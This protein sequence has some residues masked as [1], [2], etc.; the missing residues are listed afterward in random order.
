MRSPR[1]S[2]AGLMASIALL[3]ATFS[4]LHA[5][6]E[7]WASV[8]LTLA[9]AASGCAL[10]GRLSACGIDQA[11]WNGFLIFG[12][13]YLAI[14]VGPW[15][16]EHIM[17]NLVTTP[18]IDEQYSKM[19]YAPALTGERVWTSDGTGREYAGG[20]VFG[21]V[22]AE[23]TSFDVAHDR[24]TTS[25]YYSAQL[26]PIS[27]DSYRRLCHSAVSLW[28]GLLGALLARYFVGGRRDGSTRGRGEAS[29]PAA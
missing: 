17:P 4:A 3:G 7:F 11:T 29:G 28:V 16:D 15:C 25:R 9:I 24:G 27:P 26:R 19:Q 22:D 20:R 10:L 6:T 1:I 12:T 23:T 18:F 5:R 8:L 13:G 2:I 21:D 14:C